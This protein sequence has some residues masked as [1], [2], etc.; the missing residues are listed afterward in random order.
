M[1]VYEY[2]QE[3][4][5]NY[6]LVNIYGNESAGVRIDY[7]NLQKAYAKLDFKGLQSQNSSGTAIKAPTC[8]K[9]LITG[10]S[11]ATDFKLPDIPEGA[12]ALI[13]NGAQDAKPGKL[14]KV[15][16]TQVTLPVYDSSGKELQGLAIKP[17]ADDQSNTPS[18]TTG[19]PK[20]SSSKKNDSPQFEAGWG[21][22]G[23]FT[24]IV[25]MIMSFL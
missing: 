21:Q 12:Q 4:S 23:M 20:P 16:S 17:L 5:N 2:Y 7:D 15:A 9:S 6:G 22:V 8:G 19:G 3:E 10:S 24:G 14:V 18:G 11:F 25:T 1:K 13:D